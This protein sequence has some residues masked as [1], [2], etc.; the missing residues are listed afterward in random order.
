MLQAERA[1]RKSRA[2]D[3][4][5][6]DGTG[7]GM[8]DGAGVDDRTGV[9]DSAGMGGGAGVGDDTGV[10]DVMGVGGG[11]CMG[12]GD[13]KKKKKKRR[14]EPTT[15]ELDPFCPA[16]YRTPTAEGHA[17]NLEP[18]SLTLCPSQ[19]NSLPLIIDIA[20]RYQQHHDKNGKLRTLV[21][22]HAAVTGDAVRRCDMARGGLDD[23]AGGDYRAPHNEGGDDD[24]GGLDDGVGG[25]YRAPRDEGSDDGTDD[26]DGGRDDGQGGDYG[27]GGDYHAPRDEGGLDYGTGD[28]YYAPYDAIAAAAA[29]QRAGAPFDDVAT[30]AALGYDAATGAG[31]GMPAPAPKR[32]PLPPATTPTSGVVG[33]SAAAPEPAPAPKRPS[34][35]PVTAPTSGVVG[36]SA[37]APA[38]APAPVLKK[39]Q[40]KSLSSQLAQFMGEHAPS[41]P[42]AA[43][44]S[45]D[46]A[47]AADP[48]SAPSA[49]GLPQPSHRRRAATAGAAAASSVGAAAA[50]PLLPSAS[51]SDAGA[52]S[53]GGSSSAA[54]ASVPGS[55]R[56]LQPSQQQ[57]GGLLLYNA[58]AAAAHCLSRDT[59]GSKSESVYRDQ[60]DEAEPAALVAARA[61]LGQG[62]LE[63][64]VAAA[65]VAAKELLLSSR[66]VMAVASSAKEV[67]ET[68]K[69]LSTAQGDAAA[70]IAACAVGGTGALVHI[71]EAVP[72]DDQS[73]A[74]ARRLQAEEDQRGRVGAAAAGAAKPPHAKRARQQ[75]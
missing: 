8:D 10:G 29:M 32:P 6:D 2:A 44:A 75:R 37:A 7:A 64:D 41:S 55:S 46:A 30:G 33:G 12:V 57:A 59:E 19:M 67:G 21:H 9:D 28:D 38:P 31:A 63:H 60:L 61:A 51:T 65:V 4:D 54:A 69:K 23:G 39:V 22:A 24:D 42:A 53:G 45:G 66:G 13:V 27:A 25:D 36:G 74:L 5:A 48:A 43:A 50:G 35:P 56:Q 58:I 18:L 62:A 71:K 3:A 26:D 73:E 16:W 20:R 34:S 11:V 15:K 68:F 49:Q 14:A 47:L 72:H 17:D 52:T 1:W 70:T 40:A